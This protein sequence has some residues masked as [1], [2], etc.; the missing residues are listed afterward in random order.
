MFS[1]VMGL[2]IAMVASRLNMSLEQTNRPV[3]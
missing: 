1:S 3:S 2:V